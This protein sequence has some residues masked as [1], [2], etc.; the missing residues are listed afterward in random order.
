M[1]RV[2]QRQ[3]MST[4]DVQRRQLVIGS[5][6]QN[7]AKQGSGKGHAQRWQRVVH[8][9]CNTIFQA[10]S[11]VGAY[12]EFLP[13]CV[14]SRVLQQE[15]DGDGAGTLRTEMGVGFDSGPVPLRSTFSSTVT[16]EPLSR[17]H[18]VSE[19]NEFIDHLVFSWK[20]ASLGERSTRLDLELEFGL[21]SAEHQ[22][23]WEFAQDKVIREYVQ[24][25]SKR[26][27]DIEA[28]EALRQKSE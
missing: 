18:A 4:L 13:W 19:P 11:R 23:L 7:M 12:S 17:V 15:L 28:A 8:Y 5:L 2:R 25:F 24:C 6:L 27:V 10:I 22:L 20:F 26:C 21:K 9:P 16:I 3:L 1:L 14:S